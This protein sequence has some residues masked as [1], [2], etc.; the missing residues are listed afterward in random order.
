MPSMAKWMEINKLSLLRKPIF[1]KDI[2]S[3]TPILHAM[4]KFIAICLFVLL[5]ASSAHAQVTLRVFDY[6]PTGELGF[7][8]NPL[9]SAEVGYSK[10]FEESRWRTSFSAT[11]LKLKSRQDTFPTSGVLVA[12]NTTTVTPGKESFSKYSMFQLMGGVDFA[13]VKKDKW[14]LFAGADILIG[15]ASVV[16]YNQDVLTTEN[17]SGGGI[18]GGF[19]G[20]LGAEYQVAD[21]IALFFSANRSYFLVS[22][23][24][25]LFNANDYGIGIRYDFQK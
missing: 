21:H 6:R 25:G 13:F 17:Y 18:L 1:R 8:M 4:R 14:A 10:P 9:V 12:N 15:A 20:R 2:D 16:Y 19:R 22:E 11:F 24:A 7:V 23:P 5:G 3:P